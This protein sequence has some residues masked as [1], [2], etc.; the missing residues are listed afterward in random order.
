MRALPLLPL[1][2]ALA[3]CGEELPTVPS[4]PTAPPAASTSTEDCATKR[5]FFPDAD[6]DGYGPSDYARPMCAAAAGWTDKGGDCDDGDKR[7]FPG[8]PELC[9]Q[10]DDDCDGKTDEDP[11]DGVDSFVDAD[12]DGHGDPARRAMACPGQ[13]GFSTQGDDCDDRQ[14]LAWRNAKERCDGVDNDCDGETDEGVKRTF[15]KDK[16]HDGHGD[17][18][19]PVSACDAPTG[20]VSAGDDC[21]DNRAD[22]WAGSPGHCT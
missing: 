1:L 17:P 7:V 6:Q 11:T 16:D 2:I 4:T 5:D 15:Y 12:G 9:N 18:A 20:T 8:A 19:A 13:R 10:V 21:D 22:A 3:S 14:R